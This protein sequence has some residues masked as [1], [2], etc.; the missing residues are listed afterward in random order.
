M[1]R[2]ETDRKRSKVKIV[3]LIIAAALIIAGGGYCGYLYMNNRLYDSKLPVAKNVTVDGLTFR[4]DKKS[5][6]IPVVYMTEDISPE[7]LMKAYQ[8]LRKA[9]LR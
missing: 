8:A 7:G 2:N 3:I 1:T 9:G 4:S 6:D 5:E